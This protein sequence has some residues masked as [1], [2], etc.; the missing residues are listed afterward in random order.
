MPPATAS[1]R[2]RAL[3]PVLLAAVVVAAFAPALDVFLAG[4]DFEWLDASYDIVRRPLS[5]FRLIN[6]FF[7]PLVKW[8]YVADYLAFGRGGVG[9][10][11]TNLAIHLLNATLLWCLLRRRLRHPLLAAAAAAAFAVSPLHSEAVLWA[12]GRPETLLLACW[13]GSLLLLDRWAGRPTAA[14]AVSAL[15][16]AVSGAGAKESWIVFPFLFTAYAVMVLG[17][18]IASAV[19]Q[20]VALWLAWIAYVAVILLRPALSSVPSAAHYAD[21]SLLPALFKT[22][23]TLL[24]YC[25]LGRV[26]PGGWMALVVAALVVGGMAAW[27]VRSG[28]RFAQWALLWLAATLGLVAPFPLA[29]LRHNYLPLVGFWM[30]AAA[31]A[32]RVLAGGSVAGSARGRLR[33]VVAGAFV[34]VAAEAAMLQLEIVDYRLYGDLHLA[35]CR[36]Y[37]EVEPEIPRDRPFVFIDRASFRGVEY[38]AGEV[39]GCDKTFFVRRDAIW[40]LVF[41]E[42]LANFMGRPLEERLERMDPASLDVGAADVA[43]LLVEDT[44][45]TLRPDLEAVL[46]ETISS[47][48]DLPRWTRLYRFTAD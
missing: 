21:F 32:D 26:V 44:G 30:V 6:R 15:V 48:G 20:T 33:T 7:R 46:S 4:D 39:R 22:S 41:L 27:S 12:A 35:L 36:S 11:L 28:D 13:L 9:Y 1:A 45:F 42:P 5:S 10:M 23:S 40:Q 43:V 19:R 34:V 37:A 38:A 47:G 16:L 25:G 17:R 29:V 18:P 2:W 3:V 8:T 14:L 24:A 31:L